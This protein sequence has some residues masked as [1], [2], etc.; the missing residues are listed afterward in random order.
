TGG[1]FEIENIDLRHALCYATM[2][3]VKRNPSF[4]S[5]ISRSKKVAREASR[6]LARTAA[7]L[8][9]HWSFRLRKLILRFPYSQTKSAAQHFVVQLH[10]SSVIQLVPD[11]EDARGFGELCD[12]VR[13]P[14]RLLS[15][16]LFPC[17]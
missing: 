3:N 5:V 10:L 11:G 17:V 9:L 8:H 14:Y 12:S 2:S 7:Q 4:F 15:S 13:P 6:V 16:F 1:C